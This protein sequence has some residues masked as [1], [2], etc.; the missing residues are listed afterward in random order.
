[1]GEG[2]LVLNCLAC[3]VLP[4][5][6]TLPSL[7]YP[8]WDAAVAEIATQYPTFSFKRHQRPDGSVEVVLI[9]G[10]NRD[11]AELAPFEL[12]KNPLLGRRLIEETVASYL[13]SRGHSVTRD[14]GR[15]HAVGTSPARTLGPVDIRNGITFEALRPFRSEPLGFVLVLNWLVRPEV[16]VPISA[17]PLRRVSLGL[18]VVFRPN[19]AIPTDLERF[20]DS[21]IGHVESFAD[22][23]S[24]R[25]SCRDGV[26]R[27]LSAEM[28]FPEA[29]PSTLQ[30]VADALQQR[31]A[32]VA[33]ALQEE[34]LALT[35]E[36]RRNPSIL[37]DR[38]AS[39]LRRLS[40][41][42][43]SLLTLPLAGFAQGT[44][45]VSLTPLH[46]DENASV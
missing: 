3:D 18:P 36:G 31:P 32:S 9:D 28:L 11:A 25:V 44:L 33:R 5:V 37:A 1:M 30:V 12:A 2:R 10:P 24:V 8:S 46:A 40:P 22:D 39:T 6:V 45:T 41:E 27:L 43:M 4:N 21:F 19:K 16:R 20:R 38:L 29:S 7:S 34:S 23:E 26:A 13:R 15:W 35:R 42:G 17:A 14:R